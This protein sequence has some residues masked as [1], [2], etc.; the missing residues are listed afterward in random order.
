MGRSGPPK[1][2]TALRILHGETRPSELNRRE[3]RAVGR[4]VMPADLS[5]EAA[6]AWR[7]VMRGLGPSGIIKSPDGF[8]LR[9]FAESWERYLEAAK[10]LRE[11]GPLIVDRHHG[12][13][14]T[15]NPIVQVV[16]DSAWLVRALARELGLTPAARTSLEVLDP[17]IDDPTQAWLDGRNR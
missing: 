1:M 17:M 14:V 12:G 2:P 9:L 3:P 7:K 5:P 11:S 13:Q 4:P 10:V 15:K 8:V 6:R 16:K